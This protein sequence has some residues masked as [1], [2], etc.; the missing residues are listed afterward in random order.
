MRNINDILNESSLNDE[1]EVFEKDEQFSIMVQF[2][3]KKR[4]KTPKDLDMFGNKVKVGD[5]VLGTYQNRPSVGIIRYI[6]EGVGVCAVQYT[7]SGKEIKK[8]P[9][10]DYV[11]RTPIYELLKISN[12]VGKSLLK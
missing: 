5:L 9:S 12:E 1:N 8:A 10:G 7:E 2:N 4:T 11:T 6:R 3:D